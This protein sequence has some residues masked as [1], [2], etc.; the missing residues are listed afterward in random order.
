MKLLT[1]L[2]MPYIALAASKIYTGFNY[3]AFWSVGSNAKRKADFLDGFNLARN[4]ST[5]I[6]FDSARLFTC[7][8]AGTLN[9]P[10]GAFDAAVETKTNLLLGFWITPQYR[11]AP[12]DDQVNHEMI[13]LQKGFAKY[14]QALADLVI[15]L[16]VGNEDVYRWENTAESG[17]AADNVSRTIDKVRKSIAASPFARYMKDKPI[18]H[19]DTA[20]HAVVDG[21]DFIGMTA[22]PY[23][24]NEGIA[25][26]YRSFHYS[27]ED[28]KRRAGKRPVW[29]AEM[30]WPVQGPQRAGAIASAENLQKFWTDVGCSVFGLYNTFWF[31]LLRDSTFEQPDWGL[32]D[33]KSHLP[34]IKNLKCPQAIS[35]V[36]TS[37]PISSVATLS[38]LPSESLAPVSSSSSS[39][40]SIP[41][42]WVPTTTSTTHSKSTIHIN[43]TVYVTVQPT[44]PATAPT[45][46]DVEETTIT[47]S[48]TTTTVFVTASA[49]SV[50]SATITTDLPCCIYVAEIDRTSN[51]ASITGGPANPDA[52]PDTNCSASPT[53]TGPPYRTTDVSSKPY[54]TPITIS[55][56][57][58]MADIDRNDH[59][60]PIFAGP[61]GTDGKCSEAQTYTGWP[62]TNT[63]QTARPDVSVKS[64][65][66]TS[67]RENAMHLPSSS[68]LSAS[69]IIVNPN[70]SV[71][72]V[73]NITAQS[74]CK[75]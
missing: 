40:E 32:L 42:T 65:H 57:I 2:L 16:S 55:W 48:T 6:S 67:T 29:I 62:F 70:A 8:E 20:Q 39:T 46:T 11:G 58:V 66:V 30:G 9:D 35:N 41:G 38:A 17:V 19:I 27:L 31:Q 52:N 43:T 14:G 21:A 33:S 15:G 68:L 5:D 23:W 69:S 44:P 24:N 53:H 60:V 63:P 28:V 72:S 34:S 13:A 25:D 51:I 56:C 64:D 59:L 45:L 36:T 7:K 47:T 73:I 1:L 26:A 75:C 10:T 71:V 4:L 12:N 54:Y 3:G 49:A 61:L 18:G 37:S 22:Y 74:L 50:P